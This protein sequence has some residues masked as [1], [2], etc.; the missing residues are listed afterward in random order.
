MNI[1][2]VAVLRGMTPR[3]EDTVNSSSSPLN[4][5]TSMERRIVLA[6]FTSQCYGT[7]FSHGT[8]ESL[9]TGYGP[10]PKP[11]IGDAMSELCSQLLHHIER[12]EILNAEGAAHIWYL[13]LVRVH[14][15]FNLQSHD[16]S[17]RDCCLGN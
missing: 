8:P 12:I 14:V 4:E 3:S 9:Y 11:L 1:V 5:R 7:C 17:V 16:R 15:D 13:D 2:T 10:R 6:R